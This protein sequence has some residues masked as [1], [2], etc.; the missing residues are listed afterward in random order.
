[1]KTWAA[2]FTGPLQEPCGL[3]VRCAGTRE[4]EHPET[5]LFINLR[6][7]V[8]TAELNSSCAMQCTQFRHSLDESSWDIVEFAGTQIDVL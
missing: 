1:M 7:E 2:S 3:A 5:D 6:A 4:T 8:F